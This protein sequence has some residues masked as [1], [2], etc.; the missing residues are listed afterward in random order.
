MKRNKWVFI[1]SLFLLK[2][3]RH[4]IIPADY[5]APS[6]PL[7]TSLNVLDIYL[8]FSLSKQVLSCIHIIMVFYHLPSCISFKP[9]VS[10]VS[11]QPD[12]LIVTDPTPA[13]PILKNCPSCSWQID[14]KSRVRLGMQSRAKT[15]RHS[16]VLSLPAVLL[17]KLPNPSLGRVPTIVIVHTFYASRDIRVSHRWCLPIQW[18]LWAV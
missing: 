3:F 17:R 12:T 13:E 18:Y 7:F 6:K 5:G 16:A 8:V 10:F 4:S 1:I 11:I 9:A 15:F 2:N 14:E